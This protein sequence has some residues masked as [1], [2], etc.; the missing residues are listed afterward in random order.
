MPWTNDQLSKIVDDLWLLG[1]AICPNDSEPVLFE[2]S[3]ASGD[4]GKTLHINC[5]SCGSFAH[6]NLK[7]DPKRTE[8]R[9]WN[10][11]EEVALREQCARGESPV[12][13]VCSTPLSVGKSR[14]TFLIN[15]E[16]CGGNTLY[17]G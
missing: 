14:P 9:G 5:P 1:R 8:F 4:Q 11:E 3:F 16:R 17:K 10:N 6:I 12:C 13:P 7:N 15:C 2:K